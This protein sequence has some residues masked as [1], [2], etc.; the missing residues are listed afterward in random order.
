MLY[1]LV[2]RLLITA[3]SSF[4]T[5]LL[6]SGDWFSGIFVEYCGK[7]YALHSM[8]EQEWLSNVL[9]FGYCA[10]EVERLGKNNLKNLQPG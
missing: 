7:K 10:S 5:S 9:D 8:I 3:S 1:Q 6:R 4:Y 2:D